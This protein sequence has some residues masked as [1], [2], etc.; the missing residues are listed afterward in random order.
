MQ[1]VEDFN[2][3][4]FLD[5]VKG[6]DPWLA[7]LDPADRPVAVALARAI[8]SRH[9][10]GMDCADENKPRIDAGGEID[11]DFVAAN[12]LLPRVYQKPP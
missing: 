7:H 11:R 2:A 6:G 9:P 5:A 12:R 8:P 4:E 1:P 10:R 3:V